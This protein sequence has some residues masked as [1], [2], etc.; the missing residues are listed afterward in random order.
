MC[1]LSRLNFPQLCS[2][3]VSLTVTD[4]SVQL[5]H[6]AQPSPEMQPPQLDDSFEWE[7]ETE[8]DYLEDD[9]DAGADY[10]EESELDNY[11]PLLLDITI[12]DVAEIFTDNAEVN[13]F[14][15]LR[16]ARAELIRHSVQV[17][18]LGTTGDDDRVDLPNGYHVIDRPLAAQPI[19]NY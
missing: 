2:R 11:D 10:D 12:V 15:E 4:F 19:V 1:T 16:F 6:M 5:V 14:T 3:C 8:F 7:D 17:E 18:Y 9:W 13:E